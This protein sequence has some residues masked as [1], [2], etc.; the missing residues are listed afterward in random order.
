MGWL[1]ATQS[2]QDRCHPEIFVHN[3]RKSEYGDRTYARNVCL[4]TLHTMNNSPSILPLWLKG[5]AENWAGQMDLRLAL[6]VSCWWSD[7][8]LLQIAGH[9]KWDITYK[10][11]TY[12]HG[13][14]VR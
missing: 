11:I 3:A 8:L 13:G 1:K 7:L 14:C 4:C 6:T 2:Y 9:E 10:I 5:R 12:E